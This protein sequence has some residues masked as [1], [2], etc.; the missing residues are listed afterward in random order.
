MVEEALIIHKGCIK[1]LD[2]TSI[3]IFSKKL[4]SPNDCKEYNFNQDNLEKLKVCGN[5]Y[6]Y[7]LYYRATKRNKPRSRNLLTFVLFNP[8]YGNQNSFDDT[9][10]NC[11]HITFE[12]F[13]GKY[14]GFEILNILN[15][16][17]PEIDNIKPND[18]KNNLSCY[19]MIS[20]Y[21]VFS[22]VILAWGKKDK[23]LKVLQKNWNILNQYNNE[24]TRY[25]L[26]SDNQGN[27]RTW[28]LG[29][30]GWASKGCSIKKDYGKKIKLCPLSVDIQ[31]Q[32]INIKKDGQVELQDKDIIESWEKL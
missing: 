28:H 12:Y 29:K 3:A 21:I 32:Y 17:N 19:D 5:L 20:D 22:D 23:Y 25:Y 24:N 16:R 30:E 9:I 6:K 27:I 7:R 10:E 11:A 31:K 26:H 13:N 15:I 8:S 4:Y 2:C 1:K 14:D 18:E